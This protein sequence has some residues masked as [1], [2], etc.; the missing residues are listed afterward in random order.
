MDEIYQHALK[1]L[2]RRDYTVQQI[3]QKLAEK[4]GNVPEHTIDRLVEQRFLNDRRFAENYV[5]KGLD[6]G[7][8]A[9]S[10]EM[11]TLCV[12]PNLVNEILSKTAWPSLHEA[13]AARMN[14][15]KLRAPLQSR[16]AARLFR[17][18]LRLGYDEDAIREEIGLLRKP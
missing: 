11:L 9:L 7:R 2:G 13:L 18:L 14:G 3:R 10:E 17:A 1:L 8:A 4:F 16:D 6:R 15:W 12:A 5:A